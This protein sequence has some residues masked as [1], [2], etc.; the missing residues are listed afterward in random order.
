MVL[1]DIRERPDSLSVLYELLAERPPEA[2]ISHKAMPSW[3]EHVAFVWSEPYCRWY[4]IEVG[5]AIVG[6]IYLT[7]SD[8]IGVAIFAAH[9]GKGYAEAAVKALMAAEPRARYLAN[10]APGNDVSHRLWAKLGGRVIQ[11]TYEVTP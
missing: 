6:T 1:R 4:L 11:H 10:V 2:A 5:D 3:D 7:R 9:R 8:E